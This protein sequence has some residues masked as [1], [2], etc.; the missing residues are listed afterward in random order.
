MSDQLAE[1]REIWQF[2]RED[3]FEA[4]PFDYNFEKFYDAIANLLGEKTCQ[5]RWSE[6]GPDRY[7][8][9]ST[10]CEHLNDPVDCN[11]CRTE[12]NQGGL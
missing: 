12:R 5:Q 8:A 11:E 6:E 4:A 1:L 3:H 2:I 9:G 7:K 10:V